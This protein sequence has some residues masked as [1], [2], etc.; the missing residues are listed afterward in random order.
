MDVI[1]R[2]EKEQMKKTVPSFRVG[3]TVRVNVKVIEGT[4]ERIQ[5]FEGI[6]IA[7]RGTSNRETLTVRKSSFGVGVERIFPLHSPYVE[8]IEVIREGRV[9]RAKLFYLRGLKGRSARVAERGVSFAPAA[10]AVASPE[11]P[12]SVV[13]EESAQSTAEK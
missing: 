3:D 10:A 9:R 12:V 11:E 7:R 13:A 5:V 8:G 2:I 1:G 4:R 6:V